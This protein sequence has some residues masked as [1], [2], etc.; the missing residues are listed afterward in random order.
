MNKLLIV[1][2][3]LLIF[4][5][6][7]AEERT[8]LTKLYGTPS[9]RTF[10]SGMWSLHIIDPLPKDNN[11]NQ[12]LG[13]VIDGYGLSTFINTFNERCWSPFIQRYWYEK[14]WENNI[15]L[16][17]GYRFAL[18]YGYKQHKEFPIIWPIIHPIL[19]L[20]WNNLGIELQF[21]YAVA[22]TAIF[23]RF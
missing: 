11:V 20:S 13:A 14:T 19:N 17:I 16:D 9:P 6:S 18:I 8:F 3:T 1:I 2:F 22:S 5:S 15:K 7:L 21:S 12:L 10:Y 4:N 23:F